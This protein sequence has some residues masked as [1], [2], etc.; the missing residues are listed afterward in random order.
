MKRVFAWI[1]II[2]ILAVYVVGLVFAVKGGDYSVPV[3]MS[4]ILIIA[5]FS[6]YF[7][8]GKMFADILKRNREKQEEKKKESDCIKNDK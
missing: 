5:Y 1:G 6:F 3:V 7:H 4:S 8:L 2:L